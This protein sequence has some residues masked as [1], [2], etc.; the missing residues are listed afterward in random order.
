MIFYFVN[1]NQHA[2]DT[3]KVHG[4]KGSPFNIDYTIAAYPM[5]KPLS[6]T[7][8]YPFKTLIFS[9]KVTIKSSKSMEQALL[10]GV[11]NTPTKTTCACS[12]TN[13]KKLQI[14][15]KRVISFATNN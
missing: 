9:V 10:T 15:K 4:T 14:I 13:S 7:L 1:H 11:K 8:H 5:S 3:Y 2:G 6:S 12:L